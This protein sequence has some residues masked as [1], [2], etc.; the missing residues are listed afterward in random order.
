MDYCMQRQDYNY[1]SNTYFEKNK[2][3]EKS[4][5]VCY[6]GE[7]WEA[8]LNAFVK[9]KNDAGEFK[10]DEESNI[11]ETNIIHN[12]EKKIYH[13][14]YIFEM[15]TKKNEIRKEQ[16]K[17]TIFSVNR[18]VDFINDIFFLVKVFYETYLSKQHGSTL[19][20]NVCTL[21]FVWLLFLCVTS[22]FTFYLRKF[23]I[24][25]AIPDKHRNLFTLL[26]VFKEIKTVPPSEI[27]ILYIYDRVQHTYLII[28][29]FF[30][31]MPQFFLCLLYI[32][33]NGKDTFLIISMLYS[34]VYFVFNIVYH[35][36]DHNI[37]RWLHIF[38]SA[39]FFEDSFIE[40]D[41]AP[42]NKLFSLYAFFVFLASSLFALS[43][44]RLVSNFWV[45]LI[46]F[47][48]SVLFLLSLTFLLIY[49]YICFLSK[50]Y[51]YLNSYFCLCD[52]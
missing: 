30:E 36:L 23:F 16:M 17:H 4:E 45:P 42:T 22:F 40:Y 6:V 39:Y 50:K 44:K 1:A 47:Q 7:A 28:N 8:L 32:L 46:Y 5:L 34:V 3:N 41:A 12:N 37:V 25:N 49:F 27:S 9:G 14:I 33:L 18:C 20:K 51:F 11:L 2:K 43:T 19:T 29:K 35:G 38:F 31:D 26:K 52:Q 48:F 15:I 21:I 13:F 10:K 24:T